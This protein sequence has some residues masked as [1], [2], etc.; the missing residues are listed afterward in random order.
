MKKQMRTL[1]LLLCLC[2]SALLT[3]SHSITPAKRK[4]NI[5]FILADDLGYDK[6]LCGGPGLRPI[7]R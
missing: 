7:A 5:I 1:S 4:P 6:L 2:L 3:P